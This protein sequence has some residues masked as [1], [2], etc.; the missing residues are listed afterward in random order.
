MNFS[1]LILVSRSLPKYTMILPS[2]I[3]EKDAIRAMMARVE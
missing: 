1:N 3:S 2:S